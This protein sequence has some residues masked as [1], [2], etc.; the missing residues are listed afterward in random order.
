MI[1]AIAGHTSAYG[2]SLVKSL[3]ALRANS[4]RKV[5]VLD[6]DPKSGAPFDCRQGLSREL[7]RV[8]PRYNDIVIGTDTG[9]SADSRAALIAASL[10]IVPIRAD[11]ADLDRNDGL[12]ARLNSARM[13]NPGLRILFVLLAASGE[14]SPSMTASERAYVAQVMA[15]KVCDPTTA[16]NVTALYQEVFET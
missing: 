8:L 14:P 10:V 9:A 12:I 4:G 1:V 11:Q 16:S 5:L 7:D 15:A 3:A 6:T 13:F 2:A